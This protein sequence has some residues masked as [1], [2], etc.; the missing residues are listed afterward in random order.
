M[1]PPLITV[2]SSL[3]ASSSAAISEVVV[4]LP[5]VPATAIA[6]LR[7]ISSPSIS[8]RRTTGT[9]AP[10]AAST[11]GLSAL[12]ADDTTTTPQSPRL[13]AR[14]PIATLMPSPRRRSMLA[15][16]ARS[17]PCTRWPRL[18]RTSA[19]P[20]MPMPPMPTKW[21]PPASIGRVLMPA[22]PDGDWRP[23]AR[24]ATVRHPRA[25]A[26]RPAGRAHAPAAPSRRAALAGRGRR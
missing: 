26:P 16:S 25:P 13:L 1:M 11:S 24:A 12:T 10:R 3:A 22:P 18:C 6:H 9:R 23:R 8:A 19:M 14:W 7:R 17:E 21:M 5:W 4:V 20:L 2:G 15:F